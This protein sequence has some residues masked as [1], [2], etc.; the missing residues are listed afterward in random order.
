MPGRFSLTARLTAFY[1]LVSALVLVGMGLLVSL[2][3]GR[4]FVE[5]D[6]DYLHDKIALVQ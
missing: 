4:H 5:L 3:T 6:R 2:A 1:T